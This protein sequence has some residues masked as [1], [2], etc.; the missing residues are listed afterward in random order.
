[1][2]HAPT[3]R[4][5]VAR[6]LAW[7]LLCMALVAGPPRL[8]VVLGNPVPAASGLRWPLDPATV[9]RLAALAG[10]CLW[11][12]FV[13]LQAVDLW[14][15]AH[16]WAARGPSSDRAGLRRLTT[17][18]AEGTVLLMAITEPARAADSSSAT[19]SPPPTAYVAP[20]HRAA[21]TPSRPIDLTPFLPP[22]GTKFKVAIAEDTLWDMAGE[23]L[24]GDH[25][26]YAELKALNVDRPQPDGRRMTELGWVWPGWVI[27]F[28][29]DAVGTETVPVPA[30]ESVGTAPCP[31]SPDV[32]TVTDAPARG[33]AAPAGAAATSAPAAPPVATKVER[34]VVAWPSGTVLGV[35]FAAGVVTT[36][37]VGRLHGRRRYRREPVRTGRAAR[38]HPESGAIA[39][40]AAATRGAER[41]PYPGSDGEAD[42]AET[43]D[44]RDGRV[45]E[46]GD[47]SVVDPFA[48][49]SMV[50]LGAGNHAVVRAIVVRS[51]T[52]HTSD[53]AH[54]LIDASC[55]QDL[56]GRD[57]GSLGLEA[58]RVAATTAEVLQLAEAE[59]A[60]RV[61]V[62][63]EAECDD[64][65]A[66]SA[67]PRDEPLDRLLMVTSIE[68]ESDPP[69]VAALARTARRLGIAVVI[70][71]HDRS[72]FERAVVVDD[73]GLVAPATDWPGLGLGD[74][75]EALAKEDARPVLE[76]IGAA[77][78]CA[79]DPPLPEREPE[80]PFPL[81]A[82][83][84]RGTEATGV[85]LRVLGE[86]RLFAGEELVA[87]GIRD[88]GWQILVY[89]AT[90]PE[91]VR[92]DR[93]WEELMRDVELAKRQDR[94]SVAVAS[95][96]NRL[97]EALARDDAEFIVCAVDRYTLDT[98]VFDVDL[99]RFQQGLRAAEDAEDEDVELAALWSAVREYGGDFVD[100][101]DWD[102]IE[103]EREGL[104]QRALDAVFRVAELEEQ[105]GRLDQAVI[106]VDT[107]V[108]TIDPWAEELYVLG[109]RLSVAMERPS[110][111]RDFHTRLR[112]R[113]EELGVDPMESTT[114][115]IG[116]LVSDAERLTSA[117]RR[118][119]EARTSAEAVAQ[120]DTGTPSAGHTDTRTA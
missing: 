95:V 44:E 18:I 101:R 116:R 51:L 12:G 69:R 66:Y 65:A 23:H 96:R 103:P 25:Y 16:S 111:A 57:D 8:L 31:P 6:G 20:A 102:W 59:R 94:F 87:S 19:D 100:G 30:P 112:D 37:A 120:D 47:V 114:R 85:S 61:R 22:P 67:S 56:F 108:R 105:R 24:H 77:Q 41:V 17:R 93:L 7:A 15:A 2:T 73:N 3:R 109:V 89:L 36:V 97:R 33:D 64:H 78:R 50:V 38:Q 58:L 62:L 52:A 68:G 106:A 46:L 118:I 98:S 72:S 80:E 88:L 11:A 90:K 86:L 107:A 32:G 21:P 81:D 76:A 82:I 1:M 9:G 74:R 26:R 83:S 104:R 79:A 45:A 14:A 42:A 27:V 29:D 110:R 13:V 63:D 115:A 40:L 39:E 54:V 75:L 49:G 34:V 91:G 92:R 5:D 53:R 10:W 35:A 117:R 84:Q 4:G 70:L 113:I 71:S 28:P 60:R 48:V 55:L 99:W 43:S 119:G